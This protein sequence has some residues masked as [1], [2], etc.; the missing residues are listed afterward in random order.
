M[1]ESVSDLTD[2]YCTARAKGSGR[3]CKR[4]VSPGAVVCRMHGG[5]APQV[6]AAAERRVALAGVEREVARLGLR[7]EVDPLDA[8]LELVHESAANVAVYRM[9]LQDLEI[10]VAA[11]GAVAIPESHDEKG[12]RDP[13]LA[14]ILVTMYDQERDRLAR[15]S[16]MCVDAGVEERK[17]K[18]VEGQAQALG[19]V[20]EAAIRALNPTAEEYRVAVQAAAKVMRE[21]GA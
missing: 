17:V 20:V 3:R 2:G 18:L 8:L 1:V 12:K 13:A 10:T 19:K 14:H 6:I 5:A 9:A 4:R 16:K 15:Y 21:L 7:V 11:D